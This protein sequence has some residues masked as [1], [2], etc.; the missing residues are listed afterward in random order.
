[1]SRENRCAT[2]Y[3]T[4]RVRCASKLID[5]VSDIIEPEARP[6]HRRRFVVD[7][8]VAATAFVSA[9]LGMN[10]ATP[11][12]AQPVVQVSGVSLI[13]IAALALFWGRRFPRIGT[14]VGIFCASAT[15][16]LGYLPTPLLFAPLIGLL[17]WMAISSSMRAVVW[18]TAIAVVMTIAAS[19]MTDTSQA[20]ILLRTM[21]IA[22]WLLP[23]VFAGR[24][25]YLRHAYVQVVEA[26]AVDAVRTRDDEIH[27]RVTED[28]LR[29]ARE[30]HD[31]VAHHLTVSS[32]QAATA[33]HLLTRRPTQAQQLLDALCIS[34]TAALR[35]LKAAVVLL[36]DTD[37]GTTEPVSSPAPGVADIEKLVQTC[38]TAGIV[39]ELHV[40]GVRRALPP[41]IDV[42]VFRIVQEALTNVTKHAHSGTAT[43]TLVYLDNEFR[44]SVINT[45][46]AL[47]TRN[48]TGFG[49]VGMRERAHAVGATLAAG[50]IGA[51]G[52][53]VHFAVLIESWNDEGDR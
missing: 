48:S 33:A 36:R 16:L 53:A 27:R 6:H 11:N 44:C 10:V 32:A 49:L 12:I 28:R 45:R 1:M 4:R 24:T 37:E 14:A 34:T 13:A 35:E 41:L 2:T 22:L 39:V 9:L 15:C 19:A 51:T 7:G 17:Y 25:T 21:G 47:S 43:L 52:F 46:A 29:I 40:D 18:I 30:L 26:R 38:R 5:I 3:R 20:P 23:P 8:A 31:V 50:P 42:T